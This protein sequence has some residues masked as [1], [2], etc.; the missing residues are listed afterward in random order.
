MNVN[1][2]LLYCKYTKIGSSADP[3]TTNEGSKTYC[4]C[5]ASKFC[6]FFLVLGTCCILSG[7]LSPFSVCRCHPSHPQVSYWQEGLSEGSINFI[8][9]PFTA[10]PSVCLIPSK[11]GLLTVFINCRATHQ[12]HGHCMFVAIGFYLNI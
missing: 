3:K 2:C 7:W 10:R 5:F 8:L 6:F 11:T 12:I 1:Q 4:R 9:P